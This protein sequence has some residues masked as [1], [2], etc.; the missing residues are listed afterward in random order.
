MPRQ[1]QPY[2]VVDKGTDY[3]YYKLGGM[4]SYLST[5]IEIR[6]NKQGE[7]TNRKQAEA[8]A[9]EQWRLS[10]IR[11]PQTGK[12]LADYLEP[13]FD[14]PR[15]PHIQRLVTD[16]KRYGKS[17]A[18]DNRSRIKAY[19]LGD[20][21]ARILVAELTTGDAEDWK[22]RM[23]DAGHGT[24]TINAT[25]S[26]LKTAINEGVHRGE[27]SGNPL[28]LV[29]ALKD[30]PEQTGIFTLKELHHLFT[31]PLA[32][33]HHYTTARTDRDIISAHFA[34]AF[35][36]LL[37][38]TGERPKAVLDLMWRDFD[39]DTLTFRV[40][41]S[42]RSRTIPITR[43]ALGKLEHLKELSVR[44]SPFNYIFCDDEAHKYT[45]YGWFTKRWKL[46]TKDLP[47][48]D[49]EGRK[50]TP[51]SLKHSFITHMLDA[52]ADE[53]LVREYVGHSHGYGESR[54]L[55]PVQ[56]RYRHRMVDRLR[57]ELVPVIERLYG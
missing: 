43:T 16:G 34:H 35:A 10:T 47:E 24:R 13:F 46:A 28:Q 50:R 20:K 3:W 26:A 45:Y 8:Y 57:S 4:R 25:L 48:R 9:A 39:G 12:T 38:T 51:Y 2:S 56:A 6:R 42:G 27:L 41:K 15:C 5:G 36:Y 23:V 40:T 30:T 22:R 54:I 55:T 7:P 17:T 21:I 18:R 29:S 31:D 37:A 14:Y 44:L 11:Q 19:I 33:S 49:S 53:I 32:F 52:G 1:K